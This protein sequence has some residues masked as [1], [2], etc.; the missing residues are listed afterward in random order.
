MSIA[1]GVASVHAVVVLPELHVQR[2]V[3]SVLGA[4][5]AADN[6]QQ[7]G[8]VRGPT[9]DKDVVVYGALLATGGLVR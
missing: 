4:P 7:G 6:A 1:D 5:V 9:K 2:A 8:C 3:Q